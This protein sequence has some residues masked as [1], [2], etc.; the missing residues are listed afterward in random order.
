MNSS[1]FNILS[2]SLEMSSV[3][4]PDL[5]QLLALEEYEDEVYALMAEAL[6]SNKI[7]SEVYKVL[8]PQMTIEAR[9]ELKRLNGMK[10]DSYVFNTSKMLDYCTLLYPFR[11]KPEVQAFFEKAHKTK[12]MSLL[13]D[14]VEFDLNKN[15]PVADSLIQKLVEKEDQI[16]PLY[17]VLHEK[18][19]IHLMPPHF[20]CKEA[21]INFHFREK[22]KSG[23]GAREIKV[24]TMVVLA[25]EKGHIRNQELEIYFCKYK[26]QR[27]KQWLG[28]V[29]AFDASDQSNL[30][31][32]HIYTRQTIVLDA[33][34]DEINELKREYLL[35]EEE[36]RRRVSF[37][38]GS[39]KLDFTWY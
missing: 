35:L 3:L 9:N 17:K 2:D 20:A 1:G 23:Y 4:I 37:T 38:S 33:D 14:L 27:S 16:I 12:K 30:W 36:H 5:T 28:V 15:V 6:D 31:P 32:G 18:D 34:E 7:K 39:D 8:V 19:A 25:N 13:L 21:L 11:S 26:K 29:I 10:E 24:D 22:F